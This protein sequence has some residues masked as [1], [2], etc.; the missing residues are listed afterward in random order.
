MLWAGGGQ[1]RILF[2]TDLLARLDEGAVSTLLTHEL[3]H[4][5]RGDH[6]VRLLEFLASGLFWW[7]PVIWLAR[8]ELEISEEKCCDDWVVSQFPAAQRQYADALLATVDFLTEEHPPL[9][10]IACGLGEVPLLR[11][12]LKLI[13]CGTAPKSL[14][15]LGRTA[16]VATAM[17]LPVSPSLRVR[18]P[19]SALQAATPTQ[20]PPPPAKTPVFIPNA[21]PGAEPAASPHLNKL[22]LNAPAPEMPVIVA[23]RPGCGPQNSETTKIDAPADAITPGPSFRPLAKTSELVRRLLG[24]SCTSHSS[25]DPD[26]DD[27]FDFLT[28][29]TSNVVF[30]ADGEVSMTGLRDG[31]IR[32]WNLQNS[33]LGWSQDVERVLLPADYDDASSCA[34]RDVTA[35]EHGQAAIWQIN[36]QRQIEPVTMSPRGV[37]SLSVSPRGLTLA[38]GVNGWLTSGPRTDRHCELEHTLTAP[39]PSE[40]AAFFVVRFTASGTLLIA[41]DWNGTLVTWDLGS[42]VTISK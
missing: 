2:P 24:R 31:T 42:R 20:A 26:W 3:A 35:A 4:Y 41:T 38:G 28:C 37:N 11:Q 14:S 27:L 10:A 36:E 6:R 19:G 17:L 22:P 9:P 23:S 40:Y 5:R 7:H 12:R 33:D 21:H 18:E 25:Y 29:H 34:P 16:V 13:M 30:L 39:P 8:R 1:P 15:L 32:V